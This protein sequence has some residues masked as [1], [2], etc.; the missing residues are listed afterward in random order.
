MRQSRLWYPPNKGVAYHRGFW[1][2]NPIEDG[3]PLVA[4]A[5]SPLV[6]SLV[7]AADRYPVRTL[8]MDTVRRFDI[9]ED[10]FPPDARDTSSDVGA[11]A[12]LEESHRMAPDIVQFFALSVID[13]VDES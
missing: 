5:L 3:Y 12:L 13:V 9:P 6:V 8:L 2:F 11:F 4:A 10:G 7:L 1:A